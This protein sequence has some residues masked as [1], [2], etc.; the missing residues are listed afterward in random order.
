MLTMVTLSPVILRGKIYLF[1]DRILHNLTKTRHPSYPLLER[2]RY[3]CDQN[4]ICYIYGIWR[5]MSCTHVHV[6]CAH[7]S[8]RVFKYSLPTGDVIN[9]YHRTSD[10]ILSQVPLCEKTHHWKINTSVHWPLRWLDMRTLWTSWLKNMAW[11]QLLTAHDNY[12]I[13]SR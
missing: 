1:Q 7:G 6:A 12:V 4:Y 3:D 11:Q 2:Y 5:V 9:Q 8:Q 10:F 13:R